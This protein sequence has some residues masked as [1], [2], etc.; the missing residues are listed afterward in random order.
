MLT[1]IEQT[2]K[3][4]LIKVEELQALFRFYK[5]GIRSRLLKLYSQDLLNNLF[6]HPYTKIDFIMN[7][8]HVSRFTASNYLNVLVE[9]GFLEKQKLGRNNYYV[10]SAS[11]NS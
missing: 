2:A 6:T 8:L 4:T 9:K 5:H 11:T 7:D 1:A 3:S 10:N